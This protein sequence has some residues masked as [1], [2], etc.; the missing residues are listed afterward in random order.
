M[1]ILH[2]LEIRELGIPAQSE[3]IQQTRIKIFFWQNSSSFE[4]Y[5]P[6][7]GQSQ[8]VEARHNMSL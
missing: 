4:G 7:G 6:N 8:A 2:S 1:T 5:R 3:Y